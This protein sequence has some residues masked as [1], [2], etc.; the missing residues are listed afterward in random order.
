MFMKRMILAA[1]LAIAI[2]SVASAQTTSGSSQ[3]AGSTKNSTSTSTKKKSSKSKTPLN[4]R[5]NY[6][7]KDGQSATP[8]GH[9]AT[10][11]NGTQYSAIRKDTGSARGKKE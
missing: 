9:E 6:N 3:N 5:K 2:T 7:W 8:T 1:V 11:S 10:P 4:N